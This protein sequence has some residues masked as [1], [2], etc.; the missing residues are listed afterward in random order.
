MSQFFDLSYLQELGLFDIRML[1][2]LPTVLLGGA[3][4]GFSGFGGA[5]VIVP[6]LSILFTPREAVAMHAVLE[7]PGVLQLMPIAVRYAERRVVVPMIAALI[8]AIPFGVWLLVVV[9]QNSMRIVISIAVLLMVALVATNWRYTGPTQ[10]PASFG[11]GVVGGLFQGSTGVGGPPIVAVLLARD[12]VTDMTR[13]NVIAMMGS[14]TLVALPI[15]WFYDLLTPRVLLVGIIAAPLY[16]G[17]II[18]G[19][20]YYAG[21]GGA[22]Y[23]TISLSVL[24]V[25][26]IATLT[27]ALVR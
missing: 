19:T 21:R 22:L 3:M 26:A 23:R 10:I 25:I 2:A 13:A 17:S 9:D 24:A 27:A 12:E 16:M 15:L 18:L 8:A 7:I 4:R 1:I 11:I 6:V 5:L 20:R 14:L